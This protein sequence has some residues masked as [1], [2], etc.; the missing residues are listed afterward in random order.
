MITAP[1]H[2]FSSPLALLLICMGAVF[3]MDNCHKLE[4]Y[5]QWVRKWPSLTAIKSGRLIFSNVV[6]Y[7]NRNFKPRELGCNLNAHD[8]IY[9]MLWRLITSGSHFKC[10]ESFTLSEIMNE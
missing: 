7:S 9:I 1:A 4:L 5:S 2:T 3:N 8:F 10:D 6:C